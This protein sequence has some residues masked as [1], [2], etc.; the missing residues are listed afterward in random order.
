MS[1]LDPSLP[2]AAPGSLAWWA[3]REARLERR[4]PRVDG[5]TIERIVEEAIA[6]VDD[7]GLDALT[8]RGLSGRFGTGS[9]TLYRHVAS[10][11][12]LL[13]LIVDHVLGEVDV[14]AAG[15]D[16]RRQVESLAT[17]LRT[18]LLRHPNLV[19]ALPA[20]PL[21]GPNAMRGSELGLSGLVAMGFAPDA[22][23]A[24]YLV[25]LDYVLGSAFFDSA[26]LAEDQEVV[27][28]LSSDEAFASGLTAFLDGLLARHASDAR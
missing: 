15:L 5:L 10:R 6:L 3:E 4:R 11:D 8:V 2:A 21:L 27:L 17:G 28:A 7:H 22:A 13:V 14:P 23:L 19:P 18:V 24:A 16:P 9:A 12:E 26:R 1:A 25:L 20:A